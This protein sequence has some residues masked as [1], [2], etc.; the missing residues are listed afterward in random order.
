MVGVKDEI[1]GEVPLCVF[2]PLRPG[3]YPIDQM[4]NLVM[5]ELGAD[6]I[7]TAYLTLKDLG[8]EAFPSTA[9]GKVKK[10]ELRK[11][12]A[13]HLHHGHSLPYHEISGGV[14]KPEG[15]A[16]IKQHLR[17]ILAGLIGQPEESI[18][19]DTA[20]SI[21]ADSINLLRFQASIK[22]QTGK[23]VATDDVIRARSIEALA[24]Q[25][26]SSQDTPTETHQKT[27]HQGPPTPADMVHT[28]GNPSRA[29]R[30]RSA[31]E[32]LLAKLG[33][34]WDDDVEDVFPMP[35]LSAHSFDQDRK[36]AFSV[37]VSYVAR[38]VGSSRLRLAIE[39]TLQ[40]WAMFR[41]I[42]VKFDGVPLFVTLRM[43]GKLSNASISE[44]SDVGTPQDLFEP[45]AL[46]R[47]NIN[48]HPRCGGP[49]ARFVINII[50][51]TGTIGLTM[52]L[53]HSIFDAISLHAF[54]ED[55]QQN[56][57]NS[58]PRE[59]RTPYKLFADVYHQ[60]SCSLPAQTAATYHVNR[61]RGISSLLRTCWPQQRCHGWCIGNDEGFQGDREYASSPLFDRRQ[62]DND[63]GYAGLI[64]VRRHIRLHDLAAIR[65]Q[66]HISTPTIFKTACAVLNN[67]LSG[68]S[69]VLFANTQAG[70]QWPFLDLNVAKN[71]PNPISIAGNTLSVV[72]NRI[73]IHA[74]ETTGS[75]LTHLEDEQHLLTAYAHVPNSLITSQLN[76]HDAAAYLYG[77]RQ[78]LNCVP[79]QATKTEPE[80]QLLE[81]E[82]YT[83]IMVS[84][85][86]Y[87]LTPFAH[88]SSPWLV[89]TESRK[90]SCHSLLMPSV[91]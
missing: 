70:R 75:L 90:K 80:L 36:M 11:L 25:L 47:N 2:Q 83:D 27:T 34:G 23:M 46:R 42:A 88:F 18:P 76:P 62:I 16:S 73:H 40:S 31:L 86:L 66:H 50:K 12:V 22:Q 87:Y 89:L 7:P 37:R 33:M 72:M 91:F 38:S 9:S 3:A 78:V 65:N 52:Q 10:H 79:V 64:G 21:L 51:S 28:Q 53:H 81:I 63:D 59:L 74:N 4:K 77:G 82:G 15:A 55:L 68:Q 41:S 57:V 84:I 17:R 54:G 48:V 19:L 56:L 26:E 35:D 13:D 20:L 1:A 60:Y 30:T 32:P 45:Q 6:H 5:S 29:L 43:S 49:L 85:S 69:E 67:H 24:Q 71:L 39:K 61:L 14:S 44:G 8:L 58:A